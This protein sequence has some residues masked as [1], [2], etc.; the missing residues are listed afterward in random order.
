[1]KI[2]AIV[3]TFNRIN[4]LKQTI[5]KLKNQTRSLDKIIIINNASTDGTTDYLNTIND[6][7]IEIINLDKNE[8]G[9]GGFYRGVKYASEKEYDYMWIMDDDTFVEPDSLEKLV[10][11]LNK[12]KDRNIGFVC[13]NVLFKDSKPCLMNIPMVSDA[14]NEFAADGII[15]VNS[16]SFVSVLVNK[17]AVEKVGLP[18][19]EFFIWA[20]DLEF[21]TR[22]SKEFECYMISNSIVYHYMNENKGID[23]INTEANRVGRYFYEFRNKFYINKKNGIRGFY[24]YFK[25]VVGTVLRILIKKNQSKIKKISVVLKGVIA[26]ITFNPK[27]EKLS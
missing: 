21:T 14:W 4:L 11:G 5:E 20:D 24:S 7:N 16:T 26:G 2:C 12:L 8:G 23:I 27:I 6:T 25:Y 9:A 17:K 18:I 13:S 3:V 1:M 22:I 19:K 10:E 15:K